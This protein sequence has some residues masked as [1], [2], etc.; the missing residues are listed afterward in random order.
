[1]GTE[2]GKRYIVTEVKPDPAAGLVQRELEFL[3]LQREHTATSIEIARLNLAA[4]DARITALERWRATGCYQPGK[5]S[6]I[7]GAGCICEEAP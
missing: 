6:W 4:I 3:R 5:G 1:M 2:Q 7:H